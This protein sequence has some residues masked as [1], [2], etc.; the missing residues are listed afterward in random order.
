VHNELLKIGPFT[1][2]AYGVM[3]AIGF[4]LGMWLGAKRS[5]AAGLEPDHAY[6]I[7]IFGLISGVIGG[8]LLFYVVEFKS[9][10]A[11]PAILLDFANGFVVYGGVSAGILFAYVYLKVKKL[12]VLIYFDK[13]V[14]SIPLAQGFGRIGCFMAGCCYGRPTDS[15]MGVVFPAG[16]LAPSGIPLIPTQLLSAAGDF[17]ICLILLLVDKKSKV[18]GLAY[19]M[20]II[21][22]GIGRFIIE[23]YRN[24]PRGNV[25]FLS[26]SQF[27]SIFA[28]I[29]GVGLIIKYFHDANAQEAD[30]I[31]LNKNGQES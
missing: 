6:N 30:T 15:W 14:T 10:L 28:L 23:F 19:S 5:S 16:S 7:S 2:Y 18:N 8:K 3:I 27:L 20:Y 31:S 25:S 29:L 4:T 13:L 1:I 24:D 26:T 11:N 21:L 17:L 9:I 12:P 22:Y